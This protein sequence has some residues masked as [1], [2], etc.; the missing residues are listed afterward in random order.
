MDSYPDKAFLH[1]G[2][3]DHNHIVT[4]S[5]EYSIPRS[6]VTVGLS[7]TFA[8]TYWEPN[9]SGE[10]DRPDKIRNIVGLE[11]KVFRAV[12]Y[13]TTRPFQTSPTPDLCF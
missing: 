12:A 9:G 1:D 6:P 7:Y 2:L 8:Y 5:G 11:V 4:L 3:Y 10:T 13:R